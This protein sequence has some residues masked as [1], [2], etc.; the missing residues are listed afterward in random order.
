MWLSNF[1]LFG[2][3][4]TIFS[5]KNPFLNHSTTP[6]VPPCAYQQYTFTALGYIAKAQGHISQSHI[7][8]VETLMKTLSFGTKDRKTAIRWFN[9]GKNAHRADGN[10]ESGEVPFVFY[11]LALKCDENRQDIELTTLLRKMCL[12]CICQCAWIFGLPAAATHAALHRLAHTLA[13]SQTE[14]THTE[15]IIAERQG[16]D[17]AWPQLFQAAIELLDITRDTPIEEVK[18]AYRRLISKHHPDKFASKQHDLATKKRAEE[19]TRKLTD[20]YELVTAHLAPQATGPKANS[21]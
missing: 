7:K 17:P 13:F 11:V 4:K 3:L 9:E 12:E 20:A 18:L 2:T 1:N 6:K 16:L 19:N 8:H 5:S 10:N 15:S 14:I 21:S